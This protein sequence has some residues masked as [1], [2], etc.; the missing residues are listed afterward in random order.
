[1]L[2]FLIQ[3]KLCSNSD[4]M[5]MPIW[6]VDLFVEGPVSVR[7][8]IRMEQQK[9]FRVHDPFYS[10]ILIEPRPTTGFRATITARANDRDAALQ[11]AVVFFGQMLDALTFAV[12]QPMAVS[13]G[14]RDRGPRQRHDVRRVLEQLE[15]EN[16]FTEAQFLRSG[17]P[18]FLRGLGWYRKGMFTEDPFDAYLALW[19]AIELVAS[20]YYRYVPTIDHERAKHGSKSQIWECFKALWG[21]CDEW[22]IITGNRNWIDASYDIRNDVAHGR[23]DVTVE[24]VAHVANELSEIA[25]VAHR[26]LADWRDRFLELDRHAPREAVPPSS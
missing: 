15:I 12:N 13:L 7:N 19:N 14:E 2:E 10:D 17:S 9:G 20:R 18:S 3:G 25:N 4:H 26:F 6:E 22:P 5:S 16:A 21:E 1:M 24:H 8:R 11:A 23:K